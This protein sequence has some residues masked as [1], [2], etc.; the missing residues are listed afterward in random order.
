[1]KSNKYAQNATQP[2]WTH[3]ELEM[4]K[5]GYHLMKIRQLS[6]LLGR[7][8]T[9]IA[10]KA[11]QIGLRKSMGWTD[12]E[13]ELLQ[14]CY[15]SA[16]PE[17]IKS[18]LNRHT[19]F[20]IVKKAGQLGISRQNVERPKWS[21]QELETLRALAR[22]GISDQA[23]SAEIG[24]PLGS[25]REKRKQMS[26]F[27]KNKWSDTEDVLLLKNYRDRT[28]DELES[29]LPRR[30][31]NAIIKHA[32]QLGLEKTPVWTEN[33]DQLL[34][35]RFSTST[36]PELLALLLGKTKR[37]V[38]RRARQFNLK[39]DLPTLAR[40]FHTEIGKI[41]AFPSKYTQ[42]RNAVLCRDGFCCQECGC[43][44]DRLM[45][46]AHHIV[47]RRD[48][49]CAKYDPENGICLCTECHKTVKGREYEV[50]DKYFSIVALHK[51]KP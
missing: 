51:E 12:H 43:V 42:W 34:K 18:V 24:R 26:V 11:R 44:K 16:T 21:D 41:P 33:D 8:E 50:K 2:E 37:Q 38:K 5:N 40:C 45:L 35:T 31:S 19:W 23:I 14:I 10:Q 20:S 3:S 46:Q 15:T 29:M 22:Q 7:S 1:M 36:M 49:I 30:S 32:A 47:P 27:L 4:L 39:K 17:E 9:A 25:I 28:N 48:P 6:E 13:L